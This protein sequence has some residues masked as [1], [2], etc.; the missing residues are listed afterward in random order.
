VRANPNDPP[1]YVPEQ[2]T[3]DV[4]LDMEYAADPA[5]VQ[6]PGPDDAVFLTTAVLFAWALVLALGIGGIV[7]ATMTQAAPVAMAVTA[8]VIVLATGGSMLAARLVVRL[9]RG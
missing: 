4:L 3:R 2:W 5:P 1:L 8:A 9:V 7:L 6:A